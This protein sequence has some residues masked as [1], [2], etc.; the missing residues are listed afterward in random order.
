M[1]AGHVPA[2]HPFY[3]PG[4]LASSPVVG[5]LN[6]LHGPG[7]S[8]VGGE[9]VTHPGR[10]F[11]NIDGANWQGQARPLE[12]V[13]GTYLR[14]VHSCALRGRLSSTTAGL[15]SLYA[16]LDVTNPR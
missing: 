13:K 8:A 5:Q 1:P 4:C 3:V 10:G 9:T 7:T 16:D 2:G 15:D 6:E 11:Q 12:K 14:V